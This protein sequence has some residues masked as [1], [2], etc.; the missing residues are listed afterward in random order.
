MNN[1]VGFYNYGHFI[2]FLFFVDLACTYH[3]A[4][5]TRRVF[6][7]LGK[8]YWV[9]AHVSFVDALPL[10]FLTGLRRHTRTTLRCFELCYMRTRATP[11]WWFQVRHPPATFARIYADR[12]GSLYHYYC[13][14]GNTTTIEG[15]EKDKVATL[16]R[17]GKIRAMKFPYVC[18]TL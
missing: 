13:I 18:T 2:R 7:T 12:I 15:W 3:V 17:R 8:Q 1:C 9:R 4:M 14:L 16:I 11:G 6:D 10:I 5:L